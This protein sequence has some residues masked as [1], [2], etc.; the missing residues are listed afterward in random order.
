MPDPATPSPSEAMDTIIALARERGDTPLYLAAIGAIT[1]VVS[2]LVAAPD[3]ARKIVVVWLGGHPSYWHHT[4]EFNLQ[5]D[6]VAS[7]VLFDCGVPLVWIPC[8][9]VAQLL[10]TTLPEMKAYADGRGRVGS[11]F[12]KILADYDPEVL[13]R[14]GGSKVIWDLAPIAWLN[15]AAW[16]PSRLT[17]SPVLNQ[18]LTWS[19]DP[20]RHLVREVFTLDRD[21]IYGDFFA[22]LADH[23]GRP[24]RDRP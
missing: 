9:Q 14:P 22:K 10:A 5:G 16:C 8:A 24:V 4:R 13:Q 17:A 7:Q 23:A 20:R 19:R 11:Y 21:A 15:Q 6:R 1:N 2:A 18:E 3:I 12:Y